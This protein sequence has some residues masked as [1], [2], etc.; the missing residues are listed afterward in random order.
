M[1]SDPVMRLPVQVG[2]PVWCS[3]CPVI[4]SPSTLA[5]WAGVGSR[6]APGTLRLTHP[7]SRPQEDPEQDLESFLMQE[8]G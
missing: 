6:E 2:P 5:G 4:Q 8:D 1:P 3:C 7:V